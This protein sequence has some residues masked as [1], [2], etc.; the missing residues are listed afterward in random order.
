MSWQSE[1]ADFEGEG[2]VYL[3]AATQAPM[4]LGAARAAE[5]AIGWKQQPQRIPG[6]EYLGLPDRVRRLLGRLFGG[7][8][9]EFAI[10]SGASSGLRVVAAQYDWRA[11]DEI[12]IA[13][14][15][16]PSHFTAFRPLEAARG[17]KVRV[18]AP[19]GAFISAA[20]FVAAITPQT[21]L[22][23]ASVVR[24]NDGSRLDA[25]ALA[26]A[27]RSAGI[28]LVLDL[29][30]CAGA[31]PLQLGD[32]G[33][34][35]VVCSG[36]KW[37]L[38]PYGTG[39]FWVCKPAMEKLLPGPFYWMASEGAGNFD[40]L[41]RFENPV[42]VAGARRWDAPETANFINLAAFE[43]GLEW[44]AKAGVDAIAAHTAKLVE[45]LI[46]GLPQERYELAS[47]AEAAERGP[48]VCIRPR[49]IALLPALTEK[50]ARGNV[51]T[52]VRGGSLRLSPYV[53]NTERDIERLVALL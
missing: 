1:F 6:D 41:T 44:I 43:A 36:Y 45:Q 35:F 46:A 9:D 33:A 29:A 23:S 34:D 38:G 16:F 52:S 32:L 12:L 20:D 10:T 11:G 17:V 7:E 51:F 27:C 47:P 31:L 15:E 8:P 3:N 22:I 24:S 50:L 21:R 42:P 48:Y 26:S 19:R 30:Q 53:Y 28:T 40:D 14:G 25:A 4:P 39:F 2:V 18:V 37:L 13:K 49:D 5:T